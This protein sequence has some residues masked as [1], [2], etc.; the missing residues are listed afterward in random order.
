MERALRIAEKLQDK[1]EIFKAL[2][3]L[4]PSYLITMELERAREIADRSLAIAEEEADPLM[5]ATSHGAIGN[6]LTYLGRFGESQEHLKQALIAPDTPSRRLGLFG[7]FPRTLALSLFGWDS[8]FLGYPD[9]A[10]QYAEQ[11]IAAARSL[12]S[13]IAIASAMMWNL[14]VFVCLRDRAMLDRAGE[15]AAFAGERGFAGLAPPLT[16]FHGWALTVQGDAVHGIPIMEDT[17]R[18]LMV[19]SR[20]P[21]YMHAL[22]A[23]AYRAVGRYDE[24]L[25]HVEESMR[26]SDETGE[27]IARAE[28]HRLKGE[29][30]LGQDAANIAQAERDFRIAIEVARAQSAKSWELRATTSLARMLAKQ[31]RRDEARAMLADIYGWFDEGFDTLDLKDAKLLLDQL[32]A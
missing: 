1:G 28:L 23:D 26:M 14:R 12:P 27:R 2:N 8:W 10:R 9:Q 31:N 17:F 16:L 4:H 22:Y 15:F 20:G 29:L 30:L 7:S 21:T 6:V 3:P 5:L 25:R 13:E 19:L 32:S 24:G 18:S 11:S